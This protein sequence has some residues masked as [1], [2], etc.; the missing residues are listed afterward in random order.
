MADGL[1]NYLMQGKMLFPQ[2]EGDETVEV[3]EGISNPVDFL[4]FEVKPS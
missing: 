3:N 1:T 4:R 2:V